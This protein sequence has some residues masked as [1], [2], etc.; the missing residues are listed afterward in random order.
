[1][2]GSPCYGCYGTGQGHL[3]FPMLEVLTPNE[4]IKIRS[5]VLIRKI[6]GH[7]EEKPCQDTAPGKLI[8]A[9]AVAGQETCALN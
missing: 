7:T 5:R 9:K 1:M 2:K 3:W 6:Q 4:T 8:H